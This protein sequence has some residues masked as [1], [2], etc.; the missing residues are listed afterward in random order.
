M[1]T[2]KRHTHLCF[3][4]ISVKV[5][6]KKAEVVH[7]FVR[8]SL[9]A[10]DGEINSHWSVFGAPNDKK[11]SFSRRNLKKSVTQTNHRTF[12]KSKQ[13]DSSQAWRF[14]LHV[15]VHC[16]LDLSQCDKNF[17]SISLFMPR[18]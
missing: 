12:N 13:S 9:N 15:K 3:D 6:G 17:V 11:H 18:N 14:H 5:R 10:R 1:N 16:R 7:C 2:F 8:S 4:N